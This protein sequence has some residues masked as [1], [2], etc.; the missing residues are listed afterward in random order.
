MMRVGE[1]SQAEVAAVT[2]CD[3]TWSLVRSLLSDPMTSVRRYASTDDTLGGRRPDVIVFD[4][5]VLTAGVGCLMRVRRQWPTVA[6]AIL[7][8]SDDGDAARLLDAGADEAIVSPSPAVAS[9]LHALARRARALNGQ[10][11]LLYGDVHFDPHSGDLRCSGHDVTLSPREQR[12]FECLVRHAPDAIGADA[13]V[14]SAWGVPL[15]PAIGAE[16]R[17]YIGHLRRKLV[18]SRAVR[19]V[20]VRSFGYALASAP[21][22][23][24]SHPAVGAAR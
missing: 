9:R 7:G 21:T 22:H 14:L 3:H 11:R 23:A 18:V 2:E 4:R 6:L 20:T 1:R 12:L 24:A 13:L 8:A 5:R 19:I 16:L 17:V 15:T 10:H